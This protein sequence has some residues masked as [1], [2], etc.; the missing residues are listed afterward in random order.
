MIFSKF[1]ISL[2][3]TSGYTKK[4]TLATLHSGLYDFKVLVP[5]ISQQPAFVFYL[6]HI[7]DNSWAFLTAQMCGQHLCQTDTEMAYIF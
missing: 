1:Y 6:A 5:S 2:G 4:A 7:S 3:N